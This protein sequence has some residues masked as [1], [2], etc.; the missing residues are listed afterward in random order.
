ML[1]HLFLIIYTSLKALLLFLKLVLVLFLNEVIIW[2]IK[3]MDTYNYLR[4]IKL[5]F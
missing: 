1:N 3:L 5:F 4:F 2:T